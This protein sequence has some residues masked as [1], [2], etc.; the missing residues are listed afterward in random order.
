MATLV[1][2][3]NVIIVLNFKGIVVKYLKR[4]IKN[5]YNVLD[6]FVDVMFWVLDLRFYDIVYNVYIYKNC[7]DE[8]NNLRSIIN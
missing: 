3:S 1:S 5:L 2:F 6:K 4:F 8:I 7:K